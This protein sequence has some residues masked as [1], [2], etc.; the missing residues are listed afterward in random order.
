VTGPVRKRRPLDD[1]A[2][3]QRDTAASD[4]IA[5]LNRAGLHVATPPGT[6]TTRGPNPWSATEVSPGV[7]ATAALFGLYLS[8]AVL[9]LQE[10]YPVLAVNHL[11]MIMS[12]CIMI[13]VL[14]S[15]TSSGW[16]QIWQ[17]V[18]AVQW[19]AVV[20][21]LAFVTAPIGIWMS[22]SIYFAVTQYAVSVIV[23]ISSVV[24]LRDRRSM[25]V[26]LT[27]L[28][29][30]AAV[31]VQYTL[32]AA[33]KTMGHSG[34]VDFGVSL[35]PN[36]LSQL[37]VSLVPLAL[38]RGQVGKAWNRL[39]IG[40]A[41]L[42]VIAVVPTQSRG[43]E[44]GLAVVALV[45]ISSG[46]SPLRRTINVVGVLA[47]I[48]GFILVA[49]G[50]G[51]DRMSDFSDYSGG[52]GRMAIWKRGIYWMITRPWGYGI[53][54]FE[55]YF[56]WLNGNGRAAHN[57]FVQI[58]MEL[59]VAGLL[60]FTMIWF[61]LIRGLV[62]QRQHATQLT[63]T[64]PEARSEAVLAT[65]T[66][67]SAAGT[68]VTGFFL[69]KAYASVTL[70]VQGLGCAVLLGYPYRNR[71]TTIEAPASVPDQFTR[72]RRKRTLV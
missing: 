62:R 39:W 70:F 24:L 10:L 11:P 19:E 40:L 56:G 50:S 53:N 60:A 2:P 65:M 4:I 64:V 16:R 1:A 3:V 7:R 18:P 6:S 20:V 59:G 52:E 23:F 37:F 54:N 29:L 44:L 27:V 71:T 51:A 26:A 48:A 38:Y 28:L 31:V 43:A 66:I 55:T 5:K 72:M 25:K 13:V 57:S 36:D 30:S 9:R 41:I 45:L 61:L 68:I 35:D 49:H 21:A 32:S 58:G 67:A 33:A 42:L 17:L 22:G 14:A 8:Y 63:R 47:C 46:T 69:A 15:M 34:R 12:G